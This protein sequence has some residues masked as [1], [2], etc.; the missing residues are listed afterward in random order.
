MKDSESLHKKVQEMCDCYANNDPLR[1]MSL[2]KDDVDY[3]DAAVKW[4]ALAAL[5][6]IN[7]NARKLTIRR[8]KDGDVSVTAE[9]RSCELPS[10]GSEVGSRIFDAV[11]AITYIDGDRGKSDLALGVK[12]SSI[13]LKVKVKRK[14]GGEKVTIKFPE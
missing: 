3:E 6:G 10:P 11:R 1:E 5:H 14:K 13:A 8:A 12:D 9:Y 7:G 4:L 2:V